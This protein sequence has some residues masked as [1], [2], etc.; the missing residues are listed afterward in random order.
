MNIKIGC[1]G[2]SVAK[3]RY[4][5]H[6]DVV[7]L[8]Q[9]FYQPPA[10]K[11]A[12][13]WRIEAPEN[14]KFTLKAWQL[15]THEPSS[16]TYR[17][18]RVDIPEGKKKNYGSFKPTKEVLSAWQ[19]TDEIATALSAKIIIFQCPASFTPT[20]E[21][22][23][24]LRKFFD[25]IDRKDYIFAW[26]PRGTGWDEEVIKNLCTDLN[27]V[28]CVDPFKCDPVHTTIP[29]FKGGEGGMFYFRLHGKGGTRYRFTIVDDLLWL[30]DKLTSWQDGKPSVAY[31]M[32]NNIY[33]F[34]D[35]LHFKKLIKELKPA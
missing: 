14:F 2:F 34:D 10:L 12:E 31:V 7:E 3:A 13:K 15:I 1:C 21:H 9:T 23:K 8:Q 24:N 28:H 35:A 27:L 18:L 26:E 25:S 16:P 33:M 5:D 32:F 19:K 22:V 4:Y 11:T 20:E 17:R 6:F 30:N 29:S